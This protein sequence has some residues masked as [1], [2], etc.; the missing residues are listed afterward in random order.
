MLERPNEYVDSLVGWWRSSIVADASM[1]DVESVLL[2]GHEPTLSE[3]IGGREESIRLQPGSLASLNV[4]ELHTG[5]C[6]E[7]ES[8][9][10]P[11]QMAAI[12]R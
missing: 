2:V 6:A 12:G 1:A 9:L 5:P 11:M 3:L 7:L 4:P 10:T 8:L